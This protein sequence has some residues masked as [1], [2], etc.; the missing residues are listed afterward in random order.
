MLT[1]TLVCVLLTV[2]HTHPL[3]L[4]LYRLSSGSWRLL[5]SGLTLLTGGFSS[6]SLFVSQPE[7]KFFKHSWEAHVVNNSDSNN[8]SSCWT[9][10]SR[11]CPKCCLWITAFTRQEQHPPSWHCHLYSSLQ[12]RLGKVNFATT[13]HK[14]KVEQRLKPRVLSLSSLKCSLLSRKAWS[15]SLD[16]ESLSPHHYPTL[17]TGSLNLMQQQSILPLLIR[18]CCLES[19]FIVSVCENPC[20]SRLNFHKLL[21]PEQSLNS[22]SH[23]IKKKKWVPSSASDYWVCWILSFLQHLIPFLFPLPR[24]GV[25]PDLVIYADYYLPF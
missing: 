6:L 3:P 2:S 4:H 10:Y 1:P 16:S 14:H 8:S 11:D 19:S 20:L 24:M 25:P 15:G 17:C 5:Y 22:I 13:S 23:G 7:G 21:S 9:F 12:T 18:S